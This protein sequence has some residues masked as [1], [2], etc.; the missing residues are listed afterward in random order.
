[1]TI[2]GTLTADTVEGGAAILVTADGSHYELL[3]PPGWQLDGRARLRDPD[4]AV[5]A[6]AG[7]RITI[8]GGADTAM[9]SIHQV[10]PIFR[11]SEVVAV[12]R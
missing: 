11:I 12:T 10:G 9:R 7:D 5:V 6:R 3:P 2:S 1:M 4:G 8:R